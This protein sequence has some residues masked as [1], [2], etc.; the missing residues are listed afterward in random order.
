MRR[1]LLTLTLVAMCGR[2][3]VLHQYSMSVVACGALPH[4]QEGSTE[5]RCAAAVC[6]VQ[7][8]CRW[9]HVC[10][11]RRLARDGVRVRHGAAYV[12]HV[13]C[14][15]LPP[16]AMLCYKNGSLAREVRVLH[17]VAVLRVT[18]VLRLMS[19]IA[20]V[21]LGLRMACV[22]GVIDVCIGSNVC[23]STV[24]FFFLFFVSFCIWVSDFAKSI[25]AQ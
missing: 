25:I 13:P 24:C 14:P 10:S 15:L 2:R 21:S 17:V 6:V 18:V 5:M 23:T 8:C 22:V 16:Q 7:C 12:I 9:C 3:R 4:A 19:S 11:S 20:V 1:E